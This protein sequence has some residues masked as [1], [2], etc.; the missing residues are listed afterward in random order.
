MG[1]SAWAIPVGVLAGICAA[2]LIFVWWWFPRT[3]AKGNKAEMEAIEEDRRIRDAHVTRQMDAEQAV[4]GD[5]AAAGEG[6]TTAPPAQH[7]STFKYTPPAY[8]AY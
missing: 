4:G 7:P 6:G 8:T 1:T 5:G 3:W 2:G